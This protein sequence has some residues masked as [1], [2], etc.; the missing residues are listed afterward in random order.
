MTLERRVPLARTGF[1]ARNASMKAGQFKVA[2]SNLKSGAPNASAAKKRKPL[3]AMSARAKALIP[4]RQAC[5][6]EV[7]ERDRTCVAAG[8]W[9]EIECAGRLDTDE[10]L[11]R[12][13]GGDPTDKDQ[14]HCI[15]RAHH[16]AKHANPALA[17]HRGLTIR[18]YA[19]T[20]KPILTTIDEHALDHKG[21]FVQVRRGTMGLARNER[22]PGQCVN[23]AG[24]TDH[25]TRME[26]ST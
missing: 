2:A 16:D 19:P 20:K 13:R 12:S 21:T 9:P 3:A 22:S 14:A 25:G 23:T 6:A 26:G 4:A 18:G 5:V 24:A 15:C 10:P 17:Y 1:K 7:E 8:R 11:P